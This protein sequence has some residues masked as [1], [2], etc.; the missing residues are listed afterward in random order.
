MAPDR[1]FELPLLDQVR[2]G[3]GRIR[4]SD[5]G[6]AGIPAASTAEMVG[7]SVARHAVDPGPL[8]RGVGE[9][10]AVAE[11]RDQHLLGHIGGGVLILEPAT[12]EAIDR[13]QPHLQEL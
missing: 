11:D 10:I 8:L 9:L 4:N 3:R 12:N 13:L 7:Q 6:Q 5:T 2:A 1:R